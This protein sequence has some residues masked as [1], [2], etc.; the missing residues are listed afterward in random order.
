[1]SSA[2]SAASM[3]PRSKN[4]IIRIQASQCRRTCADWCS[5]D[6]HRR[7]LLR[8]PPYLDQ[9]IG[10]IFIGYTGFPI[11]GTKCNE[12]ACRKQSMIARV[13]CYFPQW[14]LS[15]MLCLTFSN[16]VT[17]MPRMSLSLPRVL[18]GNSDI[19][20]FAVRGNLEGIKSL[21]E[22]GLAS[23]YDVAFSTCRTALHVS[24]RFASKKSQPL[25]T[26]IQ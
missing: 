14:F 9:L 15:R 21:F 18:Q 2:N 8:S 12:S 5:C 24:P 20:R 22:Q 16:L 19:F 3:A 25:M 6:C 13:T 17:D 7:S 11:L 26:C 4:S 1:M 10:S 23:P